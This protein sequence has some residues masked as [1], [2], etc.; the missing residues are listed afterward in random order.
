MKVTITISD[1]DNGQVSVNVESSEPFSE[2][3]FTKSCQVA[4]RMLAAI[5]TGE[6]NDAE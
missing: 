3:N 1:L 6:E 5:R 2:D 4:G